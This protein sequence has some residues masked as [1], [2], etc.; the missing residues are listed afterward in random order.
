MRQ[1]SNDTDGPSKR[2]LRMRDF[3]EGYGISR[4]TAY[5]LMKAGKLKTVR[6]AGRR[7]VPVDAAEALC[8]GRCD[9]GLKTQGAASQPGR[10]PHVRSV[11]NP[12]QK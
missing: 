6:V 5:K 12:N 7:L 8:R 10:A 3:C 9:A 1:S 2:A 11:A 4:A